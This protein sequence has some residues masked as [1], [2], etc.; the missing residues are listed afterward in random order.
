MPEVKP[1]PQKKEKTMT[2]E[3]VAQEA[4]PPEVLKLTA[5]EIKAHVNLIQQVLKSVMKPDVHYG[6]IPGTKKNT[7][8]KPGAEYIMV[9]FRLNGEPLIEDLSVPGEIRYRI[10]VRVTHQITKAEIGWGVGEC[11]SNEEKYKWKKAYLGEYN[12]TPEDQRRLKYYDEGKPAMQVR[13]NI[14]DVAN[15][16][17]KMCKKRALID[18]TLTCTAA[19]DVFEQDLEDMDPALRQNMANEK[20]PPMIERT[21]APSMQKPAATPP[22]AAASEEEEQP[23]QPPK[24]QINLKGARE[25][26]AK[27]DAPCKLCNEFIQTGMPMLYIGEGVDKGRYHIAHRD[28]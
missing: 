9:L 8:Y 14:A 3:I 11:S 10:R 28:A 15:T 23:P 26:N 24:A 20:R 2:N 27:F 17:L 1:K 7:L 25:M 21:P 16:I 13:V 6:I 22:P 12:A 19:S 5:A 18:A 4:R